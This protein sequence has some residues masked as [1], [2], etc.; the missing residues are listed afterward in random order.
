MK[1]ENFAIILTLA[2]GLL[3]TPGL[4]AD[5]HAGDT[6]RHGHMLDSGIMDGMGGMMMLGM[7][8][9]WLLI[10]ILL[11]LAIAALI[12]YLFK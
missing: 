1:H 8:I 6:P 7:G 10:V 2:I 11:V 9:V 3:I 5:Q 12:K 4:L